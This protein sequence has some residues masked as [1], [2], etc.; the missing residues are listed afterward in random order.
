MKVNV[1]FLVSAVAAT[2]L[3]S[4]LNAYSDDYRVCPASQTQTGIETVREACGTIDRPVFE[5]REDATLDEMG[6]MGE[7]RDSFRSEVAAY[8][9]CVTAFINSYRRPGADASSTAPDEAACAHSW[10]QDQLTES[11][12]EFGRACYAFNDQ[13]MISGEEQFAGS[14]YPT[15]AEAG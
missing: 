10:A 14:C 9:Q 1:K 15:F 4:S 13:A 11:I 3:L 12:R 5:T 7:A 2:G 8:S 6:Q